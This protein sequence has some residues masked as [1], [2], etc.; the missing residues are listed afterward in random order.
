MKNSLLS[1]ITKCVR[2]FFS[3]PNFSLKPPRCAEWDGLISNYAPEPSR[4][5]EW[6]DL[7]FQCLGDADT[8]NRLK[9]YELS[10][11]PSLSQNAAV[12]S[13]LR[14]LLYERRR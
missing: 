3:L 2:Y 7:M 13:A 10:R 6:D 11:N 4:C 9:N 1:R 12:A 14:R 8:A 5:P